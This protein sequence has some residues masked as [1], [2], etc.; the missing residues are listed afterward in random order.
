[1]YFWGE[2][3]VG[4]L[5]QVFTLS[6]IASTAGH[7]H[8]SYPLAITCTHSAYWGTPWICTPCMDGYDLEML[9]CGLCCTRTNDDQTWRGIS[10][11]RLKRRTSLTNTKENREER[12]KPTYLTM[13]VRRL[14]GISSSSSVSPP[15]LL[16]VASESRV[17][18]SRVNFAPRTVTADDASWATSGET[19]V[20]SSPSAE[21]FGRAWWA[22]SGVTQGLSTSIS[23]PCSPR[24]SSADARGFDGSDSAA[25]GHN[26]PPVVAADQPLHSSEKSALLRSNS[27]FQQQHTKAESL[28]DMK[29]HLVLLEV[30]QTL[31]EEGKPRF[32][33]LLQL[34]C[35]IHS[36]MHE[37][38]IRH[39]ASFQNQHSHHSP[40]SS[41][42]EHLEH[43]PHD[44]VAQNQT[45][46]RRVARTLFG[47]FLHGQP[48]TIR[49]S[50]K[51][52][53]CASHRSSSGVQRVHASA[54]IV[55]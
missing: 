41:S 3:R 53:S 10:S 29:R 11:G 39:R 54:K 51:K 19:R 31:Q 13:E 8:I 47:S 4:W 35:G 32:A 20:R 14:A 49:S 45:W 1:M 9:C 25:F 18:E 52:F 22:C 21:A 7:S 2:D 26:S 16:S 6:P 48:C 55:R 24:A 33:P 50:S 30:A 34:C 5:S 12:G 28:P 38:R 27:M 44:L 42:E 36:M 46:T 17:R 43:K 37:E 40:K 23:S 15:E